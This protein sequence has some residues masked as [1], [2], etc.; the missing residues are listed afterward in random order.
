MKIDPVHTVERRK[1]SD[2]DKDLLQS[3]F[4]AA[5]EEWA[6]LNLS[7]SFTSFYAKVNPLCENL[8]QLLH[9]ADTVFDL[10]VQHIEKNDELSL[11]PLLSLL[12]HLAHDL[13]HTFER[14]FSRT[15]EMVARVA[16]SQEKADVI[17]WCFTC[18]AWMFKYLAKLLVQDLRPLLDIMTPY[19]S[20]KKDYIVRFSAESL[21]FLLRKAAVL[22][23]KKRAPLSLA[24]K[25][26]VEALPEATVV[27]PYTPYQLGVMSL[28]VDSARGLDRQ[29]HSCSA[30]L[31]Q[32]LLDTALAMSDRPSVQS[33][34]E[35]IL[36]GLIHETDSTAFRPVLEVVLDVVQHCTATDGANQVSSAVRLLMVLL[37]T[38]KSSRITGWTVVIETFQTLSQRVWQST[39]VT[40]QLN[41]SLATITA[42]ILQ[43]S[44]MDQLLPFSQ[45]L[46]DTMAE[47]LSTREFF[48]FSILCAEL[49]KG[50]FTDLVLS[51]LQQYIVK[52]WSND[53]VSLY[54]TLER[55]RSDN[56]PVGRV[57]TGG[58]LTVPADYEQ[59][60][61]SKLIAVEQDEDSP[62]TQQLA[63]RIRLV[64]NARISQN[65]E[66]TKTAT[67][68][69]GKLLEGALTASGSDADLHR[70][71]I[72]GW[73][74]DS[75]LDIVS[76]IDKRLPDLAALVLE[77]K[78]VSLRQPSF[79]RAVVRLFSKLTPAQKGANRAS[80]AVRHL[81]IQNLLVGSSSLKRECLELL[82]LL[83]A[84]EVT[85]WLTDTSDLMLGLLGTPY[86]P[87]EVRKIAMLLR[88][89]PQLHRNVPQDS[90]Y[91]DLI[92]FFC[93][94]LLVS[95]HDQTRNEVC[96]TL[97]QL[98]DTTSTEESVVNVAM[99]W[100]Q[101]PLD[102]APSRK[103]NDD[104]AT[105]HFS[106]FQCSNL[107]HVEALAASVSDDL[108]NSDDRF[109]V[110][111][112]DA[113]QL[114]NMTAPQN[115]RSLALQ[116]LTTIPASAERR[117]RLLVPVFLAA[118]F[119]RAQLPT[120]PD[121]NDSVS[122]HTL[123]PELDDQAWSFTDR[124]A[125]LALFGK[126]INPRV[127][128][129]SSDVQS[130]LV[131]LLSNGNDDVR[132]LA[133]QA[134]LSW[135]DPVL[136]KYASRLLQLA[137]GKLLASDISVLLSSDEDMDSVK[138]D[139][140]ET[141]L[142]IAL[143]LVY[144]VIVSRAGTS[145]SQEA[146]RKALVR[147]L[148]RLANHE[149]STFLDVALGK[150]RDV[151]INGVSHNLA[152]LDEIHVPEDQQYGFL[153]LL[154]SMLETLQ[155]QFAE[156]GQ[157]VVDAVVSCIIKVAHQGQH[158]VKAVTTTALSRSIRKTGFQ[159]LVLLFEHCR[160]I[161]WQRYLP[162]LFADA[163]SPRLDIFASETTQG[164]SGL[165]RLFAVWARS[166]ELVGYLGQYDSRVPDVL[167]QSLAAQ[168]TPNAVKVFVLDD[169]VLRWTECAEDSS[170][171][172][173]TAHDLLQTASD[174]LMKAL[175]VL[176][177]RTPSKDIL[178]SVT[179]VLPRLAKFA[180]SS[181]TRVAAVK[182]LTSLLCDGRLRVAPVV[183]GQLLRSI[184]GF[185]CDSETL[186]QDLR[187]EL[188]TSISPLFNYFKDE[189]NRQV[190]CEVLELLSTTNEVS[191][192]AAR[193]CKD[194]NAVSSQRLEEIDY[195]TRLHAFQLVQSLDIGELGYLCLPIIYNMLYFVRISDDFT[196]RSNALGCLKDMII[197]GCGAE[198]PRSQQP[199][200]GLCPSCGKEMLAA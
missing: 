28:C 128:Y 178:T 33:T 20:S 10:L 87:T 2:D 143:R 52:H 8:P 86:T 46:L 160:G 133:L 80:D 81:L 98:T 156:Y 13:G 147:T 5:L 140:R 198:W 92:P 130:K 9:H 66:H 29:L 69:Y 157:Q 50:R 97:A 101:A 23:Q 62:T 93:L 129:K 18:L 158:G 63:G 151:T 39:E 102:S 38:R 177:E 41:S 76:S 27:P 190:L 196:I 162:T 122:S 30:S 73:G 82:S 36:V 135:K 174:G 184:Q 152:S 67:E 68:A 57:T 167:W 175:I 19:L 26:L 6:E 106:S 145:G 99:A 17:E 141:V 103:D 113:H 61:F 64:K 109:R 85:Q 16:D 71:V 15:V 136:A 88:R 183:K 31:V 108:Q 35:G 44:P 155:S 90:G 138:P 12:A 3:F 60:A 197:R 185:L 7:Q 83:E 176:L 165:L 179:T 195:D 77:M 187:E 144:G 14:Y 150:L 24:I 47:H 164:I 146:R 181:G 131:D 166:Y 84:S 163:I 111:V 120:R 127:L 100:L 200:S 54:Y 58:S 25:H 45:K 78:P 126:F 96:N 117:S 94:G 22:Y 91:Q 153:R 132:K 121:S 1:T 172:P 104:Q 189:S 79:L 107:S 32:C 192:Q 70:R 118:P 114:E 180:K 161:D 115:G 59:F 170:H 134:V 72:L 43:Y 148:F 193:L 53:E 199:H 169:I 123:T 42:Q 116:I 139:D 75:F 89:L 186:D 173:N 154:L 142:P 112:E 56:V 110:I 48:A 21:A 182:L 168:S 11:E 159:C 137:E 119:N 188:L 191:G 55:L 124:K 51:R 95:Y 105:T 194:L 125:L 34:V 40:S 171:M 65:A 149:V 74:F 37:G 4:R 49:G